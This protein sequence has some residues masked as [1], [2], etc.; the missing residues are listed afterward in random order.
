MHTPWILQ[1]N[2]HDS[3]NPHG[4]TIILNG[5]YKLMQLSH[6]RPITFQS[7]PWTYDLNAIE[8]T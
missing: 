8:K 1:H 5:I 3:T 2:G 6:A 4:F 7:F